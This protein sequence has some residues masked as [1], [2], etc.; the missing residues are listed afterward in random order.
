MVWTSLTKA[1]SRVFC[2]DKNIL[3]AA[4][5]AVKLQ[6][7]A[8]GSFKSPGRRKLRRR[9]NCYRSSEEVGHMRQSVSGFTPLCEVW[10]MWWPESSK[11]FVLDLWPNLEDQ[12]RRQ[13]RTFTHYSDN[14]YEL[15]CTPVWLGLD[16]AVLSTEPV[17][18][19]VCKWVN[20][21]KCCGSEHS[22]KCSPAIIPLVNSHLLQTPQPG[23]VTQRNL[24]H[25]LLQSS[26]C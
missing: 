2:L 7:Q 11:S 3:V 18:L 14:G 19:W 5:A 24:H 4:C 1:G 20:V 17:D 13:W 6:P 25:Y 21:M 22:Y 10:G 9:S 26:H 8:T 15:F 16:F 23:F 12:H